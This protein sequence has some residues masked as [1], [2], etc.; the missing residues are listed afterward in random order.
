MNEMYEF[1][2]QCMGGTLFDE[3]ELRQS[4]KRE[5]NKGYKYDF[6]TNILSQEM[7]HSI[8][9]K[10][11]EEMKEISTEHLSLPFPKTI[12]KG[13]NPNQKLE[14]TRYDN[15]DESSKDLN[16][17]KPPMVNLLEMPQYDGLFERIDEEST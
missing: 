8:T 13:I 10:V 6:N 5:L 3:K 16:I 12:R 14:S 11:F 1:L 2:A 4:I 7:I 15:D 17:V 9:S